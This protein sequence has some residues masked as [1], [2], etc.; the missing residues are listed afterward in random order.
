[1]FVKLVQD[2]YGPGFAHT[3]GRTIKVTETDGADLIARGIAIEPPPPPEPETADADPS[4]E[5]GT[6]N[7]AADPVK[8]KKR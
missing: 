3:A 7:A 2:Y 4:A 6:E 8:K 1:M 5:P